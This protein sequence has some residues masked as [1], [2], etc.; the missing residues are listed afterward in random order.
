MDFADLQAVSGKIGNG[1]D[2][3]FVGV[4]ALD[5]RHA[6]GDRFPGGGQA[7][8]VVQDALSRTVRPLLENI[9]VDMLQVG[10]EQID[11]R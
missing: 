7:F 5:Q 8:Q 1:G 10:E 2:I 9:S 6:D 11:V 4:K 3:A